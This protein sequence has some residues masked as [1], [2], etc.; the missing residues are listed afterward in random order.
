MAI[1][2]SPRI[3]YVKHILEQYSDENHTLSIADINRHLYELCGQTAHRATLTKDIAALCAFGMDIITIHSTQNHYFV[4][5]RLFET[6][7]LRLLIDAIHSSKCLTEKKSRLLIDKLAALTSVHQAE[8]LAQYPLSPTLTKPINEQIYYIIDAIHA[9]IDRG[10]KIRFQYTDYTPEKELVLRGDGEEYLLSPY[11]CLWN[12]DY[13]YVIG[14]S[15]KRQSEATFRVDR[16]AHTPVVTDEPLL[17]PSEH[18][19]VRDYASTMFR[20]F[21]GEPAVVELLCDNDL[22]KTVIDRFGADVHTQVVDP[23]R[24][25]VTASVSLSPTFYGWVFSFGGKIR[26]LSPPS[27]VDDYRTMLENASKT[28]AL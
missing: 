24:F 10:R 19:D 20:M 16:I 27:A 11:A 12:G 22:M 21:Q 2:D 1:S 13:Y 7:E 14:W 17:P 23:E 28:C 25:R 26:L 5:S 6:P 15:D 8:A 9:A 18:F 4:G 3:L